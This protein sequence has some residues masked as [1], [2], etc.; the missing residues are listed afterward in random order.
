MKVLSTADKRSDFTNET[1]QVDM[2][3]EL[4]MRNRPTNSCSSALRNKRVQFSRSTCHS[5]VFIS[6]A[7]ARLQEAPQIQLCRHNDIYS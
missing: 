5:G 1:R 7:I 2:G 4:R 3:K 6:N